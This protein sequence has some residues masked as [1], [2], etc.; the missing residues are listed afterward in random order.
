MNTFLKSLWSAPI[1]RRFGSGAQMPS[2]QETNSIALSRIHPKRCPIF[3]KATIGT[4]V[5]AL[6]ICN[7][8]VA[9][10]IFLSATSYASDFIIAAGAPGNDE[11]AAIFDQQITDWTA[12]T[13]AIVTRD[14]TSFEKSVAENATK[15]STT[16]LWLILI[17][18]GTFDERSAKF[19]FIGDDL[20]AEGL[21]GLIK[22]AK[23]PLVI[24]NT[25]AASAPFL[26]KLSGP[27]RIIITATKSGA[28]ESYAHFGEYFSQA[29]TVD[30][31]K[32]DL[33]SDG[34]VSLLEA[35]LYASGE[36]TTFFDTQGRIAT[37]QALIDDNGDAMGTPAK[38]FRGVR[39]IKAAKSQA[40]P[41]GLRAHQ[42]QLIP[43][44]A[45]ALLS[46]SQKTERDHLE[47]GIFA[48]RE[49]KSSMEESAYY[50]EL[51]KIMLSLA[52][53]YASEI[54]P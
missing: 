14:L 33:D 30:K 49:K 12:A 40:Q 51:E 39:A 20:S 17:G 23:R 37:E 11:F 41:D 1:L 35:F 43:S 54:Q 24:I 21:A 9:A 7:T 47:M 44:P 38:F 4:Q 26:Q 46:E 31:K 18:H 22:E 6:Q 10:S 3:A 32:T 5:T 28:E 25:T 53:I 13:A 15:E 8:L 19:N 48:L 34:G 16:P 36:V 42:I 29:L 2:I 52:K 27:G 50:A 45:E